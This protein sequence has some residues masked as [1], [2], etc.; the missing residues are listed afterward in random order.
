MVFTLPGY[1]QSVGFGGT[2]RPTAGF[3]FG[4][5]A[6]VRELAAR[7]GW[8]TLY[9]EFNQQYREVENRRFDAQ[10]RIGLIPDLDIDL[11]FNRIYQENYAEK[12]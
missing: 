10:M 1:T 12:L 5:Q 9:Q 3:V 6:E 11:T 8:L 2:L 4:S 7:N